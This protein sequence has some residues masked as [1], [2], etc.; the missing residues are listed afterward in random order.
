M[1]GQ[2]KRTRLRPKRLLAIPALVMVAFASVTACSSATTE[3]SSNTLRLGY[4]PNITHAIPV[5]GIANG[6]FQRALGQTQLATQT[7]NSGTAAVEAINAGAVDAA[8]VGPNPAI[9]SWTNSGGTSIRIVSGAASGGA[10]LVVRSGI[11]ATAD[12]L[13][14]TTLATPSLG[15]TQDVALRFWLK[16]QGLSAPK[17]SRGDVD[18]IPQQNSQTLALFKRGEIDGAWVPEPWASRLV[19][20]GGGTVIVNEKDLWP[21]GKF[22]T[23]QLIVSQEYLTGNPDQVKALLQ[24]VLATETAIT[25]NMKKARTDVDAALRELTGEGLDGEVLARAWDNIDITLDPIATSL[26]ADL[27]H[28][29]DVKISMP[30]DL[31]GIYDLTIINQ[32]LTEAGRPPVSAGGLGSQ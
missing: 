16:Q 8:F 32:L 11:D 14:G 5:L 30:V 13:R 29:I 4:F 24:G 17:D 21:D 22:V 15:N 27:N 28:A 12:S 3:A 1:S 2:H 23:T 7:F 19:Q 18:V 31:N 9:S 25:S 26:Q 10:A 6:Q 20:E